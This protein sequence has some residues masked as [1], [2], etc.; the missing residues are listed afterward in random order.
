MGC[1]SLVSELWTVGR[2][3]LQF[4]LPA[5]SR[6]CKKPSTKIR[7]KKPSAKI[8]MKP[9]PSLFHVIAT[10][11][12]ESPVPISIPTGPPLTSHSIHLTYSPTIAS[13]TADHQHLR[14]HKHVYHSL[15][16]FFHQLSI[17]LHTMHLLVHL[18]TYQHPLHH[19]LAP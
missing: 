13:D 6:P 17:H 8:R 14:H 16:Q 4:K 15:L 19:L 18:Q 3:K 9:L 7:T 10:S 2:R 5:D 12:A 1:G 11:P